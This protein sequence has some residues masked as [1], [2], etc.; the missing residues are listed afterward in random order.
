MDVTDVRDPAVREGFLIGKVKY[1]A[2]LGLNLIEFVN[3]VNYCR[4]VRY[5][6]TLSLDIL[7]C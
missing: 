2:P 4:S 7:S 5:L 3:Y 6:R 1:Y